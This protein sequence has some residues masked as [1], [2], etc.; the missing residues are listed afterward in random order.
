MT[1]SFN[2]TGIKVIDNNRSEDYTPRAPALSC[3]VLDLDWPHQIMI[4]Q[5][6][7]YQLQKRSTSYSWD[8]KL[9]FTAVTSKQSHKLARIAIAYSLAYL[10]CVFSGKGQQCL[11]VVQKVCFSWL[12]DVHSRS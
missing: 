5:R 2:V 11:I 9:I 8:Y 1:M 4:V 10:W 6:R 3:N 12:P 7:A